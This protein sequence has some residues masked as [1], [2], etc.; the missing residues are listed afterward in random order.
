VVG[1]RVFQQGEVSEHFSHPPSCRKTEADG[2]W[3]CAHRQLG[4][5]L[6]NVGVLCITYE[7]RK[8]DS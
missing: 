8:A 7:V 4:V 3:D 6:I 1:I 5:M 2:H